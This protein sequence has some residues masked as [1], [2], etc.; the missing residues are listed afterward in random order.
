M[1]DTSIQEEIWGFLNQLRKK[2]SAY[3]KNNKDR[4]KIISILRDLFEKHEQEKQILQQNIMQAVSHTLGNMLFVQ[5]AITKN[6]LVTNTLEYDVKRLQLFQTVTASVL[7]SIKVAF[8]GNIEN[9]I[10]FFI[11]NAEDKISLISIFYFALSINLDNLLQAAGY[12]ENIYDNFFYL[13]EENEDEIIKNTESIQKDDDFKVLELSDEDINRF[14]N[15]FHSKKGSLLN[16]RFKINTKN[17]KNIFI[18]KDSYTFSM[19]FTILQELIKNMFKYGSIDIDNKFTIDSE[20]NEDFYIIYFENNVKIE[21]KNKI[22]TLRG[23]EMIKLFANILGGFDKDI[24]D[25]KFSIKI[26][27]KKTFINKEE[28]ENTLG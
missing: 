23:L 15:F 20:E 3:L 6:L 9:N 24:K 12:W 18:E 4:R 2:D 8:G 1:E 27:I 17:L 25:D 21:E 28:D 26:E 11:K 5:K 19:I 16:Q 13:N 10:E 7:D 14:I 22:G